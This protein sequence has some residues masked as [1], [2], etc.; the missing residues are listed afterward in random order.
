MACTYKFEDANGIKYEYNDIEFDAYLY[1]LVTNGSI[2]DVESLLN[3]IKIFSLSER[4]RIT[5][6]IDKI[7][8]D[9]TP[10]IGKLSATTNTVV[11]GSEPD[12]AEK[13]HNAPG[14]IGVTAFIT[15]YG[16]PKQGIEK[17]IVDPFDEERWE[18]D[19]RKNLEDEGYTSDRINAIIISTKNKW[20]LFQKYGTEVHAIYELVMRG[21]VPPKSGEFYTKY[22]DLWQKAYDNAEAF[23][24]SLIQKWGGGNASK[25]DFY[26]ELSIRTDKIDP[27]LKVLL[28][29]KGITHIAGTIDLLV[30]D[31]YGKPHIYDYKTSPKR[32]DVSQWDITNARAIRSGTWG[33]DKM[34]S[35]KNQLAAY[36]VM[37]EQWGIRGATCE[38]VPIW[39]DVKY[40]DE[41]RSEVLR[42]DDVIQ[43][44]VTTVPQTTGG[45]TYNNWKNIIPIKINNSAEDTIELANKF[46]KLIPTDRVTSLQVQQFE[47]SK[48]FYKQRVRNVSSEDTKNY[49]KYKYYFVATETTGRRKYC[50]D[51]EDLDKQLDAYVEEVR[52][53]K[54]SE[55]STLANTIRHA[56]SRDVSLDQFVS[57]YNL[58]TRDFIKTQFG[59][60]ITDSWELVSDDNLIG[61]GIFIFQKDGRSEVVV[62]S[63]AP[64]H[65]IINLGKGSTLSGRFLEDQL[66]DSKIDLPANNGNIDAI[67]A[68][69][70]IADNP[71]VF[72]NAK[73]T[74]VV[75]INPWRG[76]RT[77][78]NNSR[79]IDNYNK[80]VGL[81]KDDDLNI[82]TK[83][84]FWD[85]VTSML[86]IADSYLKS[87]EVSS[88]L[89]DFSMNGIISLD[90]STVAFTEEYVEHAMEVLRQKY[91]TIVSGDE[92]MVG[93]PNIWLAY[94]YLQ[95]TALALRGLDVYNELD[96]GQWMSAGVKAGLM[97]ASTGYSPS[98]NFRVFDDVM[99]Q[100][101]LEVRM[102]V[103]KQGRPIL[104]ALTKFYQEKKKLNILGGEKELFKNW[105]RRTPTG[106]IDPSFSL[107]DPN[108]PDFDGSQVEREA[109]DTWLKT[110]A[111]LKYRP[112]AK[113]E[114]DFENLVE[115]AKADGS[116]YFVPLTEGGFRSQAKGLG[117][118]TALKNKWNQYAELTSDVFAGTAEEK[119]K[120]N[121]KRYKLYNK[122]DKNAYQREILIRDHGIGFFETDLE[123]V[124][125]KALVAYTKSNLSR[126]YIPIL[127]GMRVALRVSS[128]Y[129]GTKMKDTLEGFDKLVK[130]KFYEETIIDEK[131]RPY[132]RWVSALRAG[133]SKLALGFNFRSFFRETF[134]GTWMGLSRSAVKM[135]PGIDAKTY[136]DAAMHVVTNAHKNFSN[137]SLLQQLNMVYG[138]AN[139]SI[140]QIARQRRKNWYGIRNWRSDTLFMTSTAPDFQ[141]RMSILVAKMMGDGCWEAHSLDEKG[142]L[143]YDFK[144]DKRFTIYLSGDTKNPEYLS[145]KSNYLERIRELNRAGIKKEDGS[146]YKEGDDLPMAYLPREVQSIKN[147]ADLLYGHYDEESRSLISDMF[148][149]STFMQYKTYLTSRVEQWT[150]TPGQYNTQF[151]V[152]AEDPITKEK[153]YKIHTGE[154]D[155][156]GIPIIEIKP[157]SEIENFDELQ[158][159]NKIEAC[160]EWKGI[161]MEGM[162][163]SFIKFAKDIKSWNIADFKEK[164]NNPVERDNII[165]GLHDCLLMTLM[166]ML[167]TALFGLALNGE[168][169]TDRAKVSKAARDAG[170]GPSFLYNVAYGSFE[171]FPFWQSLKSMFGD[172]NPSMVISAKRIVENS[173][174]VIMGNKSIFQAVTN[175]VG[176][177]S[178]L[179]GLANRLAQD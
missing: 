85:D 155:S 18:A 119:E 28:A 79:W 40:T 80:L 117:F 150:L 21:K 132:A 174:A 112:K 125:N 133:L 73:I 30:V 104:E 144:N 59:R 54:A 62:M 99:Q 179:K 20:D 56:L 156:S 121:T 38:V 141:H 93:D 33:V 61:Y 27:D 172:F 55:L 91:P 146:D 37:L 68:L 169:T 17:Q 70:Y 7:K 45:E 78:I 109:L 95:R 5:Q 89:P 92:T 145:Q 57:D 158:E 139:Y 44:D 81:A 168:W 166:M 10:I 164:W 75:T 161:P 65:N 140:G 138:M 34:K 130:A 3:S 175:T 36:N 31:Q 135:L 114:A 137:T 64:L 23:K 167:V 154:T 120:Y 52:N 97:V 86:S 176:A 82:L 60:Y 25:V 19:T 4:E 16:D 29:E 100:Y 76:Q 116:Y 2:E 94:S 103:E 101:A 72:K 67:K 108:S 77:F 152:H 35:V 111:E 83:D 50:K 143:K 1:D 170:W 43:D 163:R 90:G 142:F 39:F 106:E 12:I 113:S 129:G 177:A 48:S 126:K 107:K 9:V 162:G 88:E 13:L 15:Q 134:Q 69:V 53:K 47:A 151:L 8:A 22:P 131:L 171:D 84:L 46:Q 173:G 124:I 41:T 148:L 149:G 58:S 71:D 96:V 127:D 159:Q 128:R 26:P 32:L 49:G 66:T 105:F 147:F 160:M 14:H 63:N 98:T 178:D 122:Y 74:Q 165:L 51:D 87:A 110:M 11:V 136:V 118:W 42:I 123:E 115:Q 24:K 102:G 157:R 6:A 153:L